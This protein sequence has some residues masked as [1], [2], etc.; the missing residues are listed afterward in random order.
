M[1]RVLVIE[2]DPELL[3]ELKHSLEADGYEV[4]TA[5]DGQNGLMQ[6][7][8][9]MPDAVILDLTLPKL[10]G[11]DVCRALRD[12]GL[13]TPVLILAARSQE[14]DKMLAFSLGADDYVTKPFS[15]K[16]LLAR[17]RAIIRRC[18]RIPS[19]AG[20]HRFGDLE[21]NFAHQRVRR[22][23]RWIKLS[24]LEFEVL[25]YLIA[26]RGHIVSREHLQREVWGY[27]AFRTTRTVDNL[28]G[29][30]RQKLEEHPREPRHILTVYGIGY[31]FV[32]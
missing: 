8:R 32:E 25:R 9:H 29:R 18:N 21:I 4:T 5:T 20:V 11:L 24:S 7:V 16:E 15:I 23:P 6:V 19:G 1:T 12:R 14:S 10:G 28:V 31:K 27:H 30:L 17:L 22:G 26:R 3:H 2:D 13:E